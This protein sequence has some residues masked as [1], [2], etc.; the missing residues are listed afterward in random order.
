[1][2]SFFFSFVLRKIYLPKN[3]VLS[4]LYE[5][6]ATSLTLI[7][8]YQA[9]LSYRFQFHEGSVFNFL[10]IGEIALVLPLGFAERLIN[11]FQ[12]FY[13]HQFFHTLSYVK[14]DPSISLLKISLKEMIFPLIRITILLVFSFALFALDLNP[15]S[16]L[17]FV[18]IQF[19][20]MTLF[21]LLASVAIE[22]Y[23]WSNRGLRFY[24]TLNSIAAILGGAYFP[25]ENFPTVIKNISQFFP[26]S[27]VLSSSRLVF[28]GNSSI[29]IL[30]IYM[31]S[32]ICALSIAYKLL[33]ARPYRLQNI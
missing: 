8:L 29:G 20:A 27:M 28:A 5:V 9:G 30:I 24:H 15:Q 23:L 16:L 14:I 10:I 12:A 17:F 7:A 32:W 25:A 21:S 22:L 4:L 6:L 31:L 1:M 19:L 2:I 26:H 33:K 11:N 18:V 3:Q 13:N